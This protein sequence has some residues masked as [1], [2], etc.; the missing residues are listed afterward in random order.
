MRDLTGTFTSLKTLYSDIWEPT[1]HAGSDRAALMATFAAPHW[2]GVYIIYQ[3]AQVEPLYIGSAG[4]LERNANGVL[5]R[6]GQTVR[7]RLS[8]ANTPYFFDRAN[9]V[10]RYGPT[11]PTVP[12]AGYNFQIPIPDIHIESFHLPN[13]HAATVLEYVLLQ[14]CV[15]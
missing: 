2:H 8:H 12:P 9:P 5:I 6:S 11:T 10:W 13:T 4:K 7:R 1:N 15:N 14:G 3:D